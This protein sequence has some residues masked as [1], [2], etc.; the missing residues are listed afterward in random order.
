[1]DQIATRIENII[2]QTPSISQLL[3]EGYFQPF[4]FAPLSLNTSI[5]DIY[6]FF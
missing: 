6:S 1:M 5:N 3:R 4:K 2:F